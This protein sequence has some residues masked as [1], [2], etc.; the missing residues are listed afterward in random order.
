MCWILGSFL[1]DFFACSVENGSNLREISVGLPLGSCWV[2]AG[3][4]RYHALTTEG[5]VMN[6]EQL[7]KPPRKTTKKRGEKNA[8][9]GA[10]GEEAAARLLVRQGY[11]IVAR[12]WSGVSG[13]ADIVARDGEILVFVEVKTRSGMTRGMPSEAVNKEKR[14]RYERIAKEFCAIHDAHDATVRFDVVSIVTQQPGRAILRHYIN[15]F[16][17]A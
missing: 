4:P 3:L 12:N 13:E 15:A 7:E 6:R 14:R 2:F 11:D 17:V 8:E 16:G 5:G 1:S 10:K 9:L